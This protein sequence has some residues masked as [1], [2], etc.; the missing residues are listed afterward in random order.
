MSNGS[1][2]NASYLYL[3]YRYADL[4]LLWIRIDGYMYW[5]F[6]VTVRLG[7]KITLYKKTLLKRDIVLNPSNFVWR[8][9][10]IRVLVI[11]GNP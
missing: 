5:I 4:Y 2:L 3:Y 1:N 9:I 7:N 8:H 10:Q 11:R 6:N